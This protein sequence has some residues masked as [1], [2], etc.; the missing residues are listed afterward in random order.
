MK[1]LKTNSILWLGAALALGACG[2]AGGGDLQTIERAAMGK[3][4]AVLNT[5][6][7]CEASCGDV[8]FDQAARSYCVCDAQC[9]QHGDCC[10][11]KA[12]VCDPPPPPC[13]TLD[14]AA[15][16]A[17]ED[18]E[19][20]WTSGFPGPIGICQDKSACFGAW[21]DLQG[22]CRGPAD[23]VLPDE[24]CAGQFCGGIAGIPCP[25]GYQCTL[26]GD[27]PD[28]G[29]KCELVTC[30]PVMCALYCEYGYETDEHGCQLCKCKQGW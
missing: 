12:Q 27:Y 11:D 22:N 21:L 3:A 17:R 29:G 10:E 8:V 20:E 13:H 5:A 6:L 28:A 9:S 15:C 2:N 4:D 16:S 18:C 23:G 7:S 19:F 24:C 25:Q 26:D 14:E 30:L 1:T